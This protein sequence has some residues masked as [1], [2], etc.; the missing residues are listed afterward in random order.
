MSIGKIGDFFNLP[1]NVAEFIGT[2]IFV[3]AGAGS[4]YMAQHLGFLGDGSTIG[5]NAVAHW[6]IAIAHGGAM[7]LMVLS[8]GAVSG[9]H[10][11]PA[12]TF[13]MLLRKKVTLWEMFGYWVFQLLGGLA[14]AGLLA[15]LM[16]SQG[17][18]GETTGF[19][20]HLGTPEM[21]TN[22]TIW[23]GFGIEVILT[24]VLVFCVLRGV[25]QNAGLAM[26]AVVGGAVF[27]AALV[28]GPFTGASMNLARWFGPAL[29]SGSWDNLFVYL[30]APFVGAII[31]YLANEVVSCQKE[32][33]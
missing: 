2:F 23:V 30:V 32:N 33:N 15:W 1:K 6:M 8:L 9:A 3:L 19:A 18:W 17:L 27:G 4:I 25:A 28:G 13:A 24:F 7:C 31:A 22:I 14:A 26:G 21:A 5:S 16:I 29:L 10:F 12:V 20:S 11:N